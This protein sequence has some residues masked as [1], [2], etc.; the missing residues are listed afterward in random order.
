MTKNLF[1]N[2]LLTDTVG[3]YDLGQTILLKPESWFEI[4]QMQKVLP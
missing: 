2:R 4:P 1:R 3:Y